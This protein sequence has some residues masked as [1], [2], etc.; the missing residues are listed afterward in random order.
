ME[1]GDINIDRIFAGETADLADWSIPLSF[2][3]ARHLE[4]I[5]GIEPEGNSWRIKDRVSGNYQLH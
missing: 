1:K 2:M 4:T 3:K 5:E